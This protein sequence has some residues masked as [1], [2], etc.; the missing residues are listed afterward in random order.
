LTPAAFLGALDPVGLGYE[1][2]PLF[3]RRC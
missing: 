3:S 1:A 2:T